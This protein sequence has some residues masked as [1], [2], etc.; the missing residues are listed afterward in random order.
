MTGLL[1]Q[2]ID[3]STN[4]SVGRSVFCAAAKLLTVSLCPPGCLAGLC[5][6]W[7]RRLLLPQRLGGSRQ[8]H[9]G[10][11][12]TGI[13]E[14]PAGHLGRGETSGRTTAAVWGG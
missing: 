11:E 14:L 6:P 1:S 7:H 2:S 10:H 4:V 13:P 8:S 9:A 3:P 5:V 12:G